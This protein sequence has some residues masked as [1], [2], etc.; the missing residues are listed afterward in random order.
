M[1]TC[2]DCVKEDICPYKE[3]FK[4]VLEKNS[5]DSASP[6]YTTVSCRSAVKQTN[7]RGQG[8]GTDSVRR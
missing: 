2:K 3:E 7:M 4:T 6:I 1:I 8:V 5:G